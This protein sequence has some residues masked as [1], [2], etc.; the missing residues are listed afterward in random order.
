[1]AYGDF[2]GDGRNDYVTPLFW[3]W[4]SLSFVT[5]VLVRDDGLGGYVDAGPAAPLYVE[6]ESTL[7]I[8]Q[9]YW[10]AADVDGDGDQD[11]LVEGGYW[12]NGGSGFF[13]SFVPAFAGHGMGAA[14]LDGDGEVEAI[15]SVY[16]GPGYEL[17]L[18]DGLD[19]AATTVLW[20]LP[21]AKPAAL[22]R[23]IDLDGDLGRP[24]PR[25]QQP[26][27]D[28][29]QPGRHPD[30]HLH[31]HLDQGEPALGRRRRRERRRPG[32]PGDPA[33]RGPER[34]EPA[35][36]GVAA[37]G[38]AR[39][40]APPDRA[41]VAGRV[42]RARG[43]GGRRRRRRPRPA[44]G[45]LIR[46]VAVEPP[47]GGL[48]RQ[49]GAGF[50]GSG[51][52]KPVLGAQGPATSTLAGELRLVDAVGGGTAFL[53]WGFVEAELIDQPLPGMTLYI[54]DPGLFPPFPL[55]GPPGT[56]GAG[57]LALTLPALTALQGLSLTHQAFVL[58]PG[59]ATG[60]S[61]SNGLEIV[62]GP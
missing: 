50:P 60:W 29:P 42:P 40:R 12:E 44:G 48:V 47:G 51:G 9:E 24:G 43:P 11:I 31:R 14:D 45:D 22:L 21:N 62:Y 7:F 53:V 57:Q 52:I 8:D 16:V 25:R 37:P 30:P 49:F 41:R 26:A 33:G 46:G 17:R 59:S 10:A 15:T 61:A 58:D 2:D 35:L 56:A 36:A 1:M 27:R 5:M 20:S 19:G 23:D 4:P 34:L 28:L 54:G 6:I 39:G 32:R 13:A 38:R 18:I 55:G 3:T